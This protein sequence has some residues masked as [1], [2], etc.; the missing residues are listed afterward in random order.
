MERWPATTTFP[1]PPGIA[2]PGQCA[3]PRLISVRVM[4]SPSRE[5]SPMAPIT[6]RPIGS[7]G[8]SAYGSA[9]NGAGTGTR[10]GRA[11][12][13]VFATR[14]EVTVGRS[15]LA[16]AVGSAPATGAIVVGGAP[17]VVASARPAAP[18]VVANQTAQTSS[19]TPVS[20]VAALLVFIPAS[21]AGGRTIQP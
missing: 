12:T 20:A 3:G 10:S 7:S 2:V 13:S 15:R 14:G 5:S 16:G 18:V 1:I 21:Y 19:T 17:G 4:P 11:R 9:G 8:S 6:I